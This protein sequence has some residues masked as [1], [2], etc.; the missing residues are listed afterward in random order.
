MTY[1]ILMVPHDSVGD[2]VKEAETSFT[3]NF[4]ARNSEDAMN[5]AVAK[6]PDC[7]VYWFGEEVKH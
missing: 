4:F 7:E 3:E 2:E 1:E 6:Y 5:K